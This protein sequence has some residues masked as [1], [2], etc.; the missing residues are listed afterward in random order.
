MPICRIR[1]WTGDTMFW[2]RI[3]RAPFLGAPG[4]AYVFI[5]GMLTLAFLVLMLL[6][7]HTFHMCGLGGAQRLQQDMLHK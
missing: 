3:G 5:Y 7:G 1:Q 2:Y 6:R 4:Q